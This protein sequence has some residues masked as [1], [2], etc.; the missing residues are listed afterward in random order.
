MTINERIKELG[1]MFREMKVFPGEG[2]EMDA[3]VTV[4]FPSN[5]VVDEDTEE[6]YGVHL[7]EERGMYYFWAPLDVGQEKILDAIEYNIKRNREAQIKAELFDKKL[8]E[9][10]VIFYDESNTVDD[11]AGLRFEIP[12]KLPVSTIPGNKKEKK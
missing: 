12:T 1:N 10:K 5:W 9:L 2:D 7:A 4:V 6:K 11:L 8:T 3:C